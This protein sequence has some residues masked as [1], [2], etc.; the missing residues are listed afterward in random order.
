MMVAPRDLPFR[1]PLRDSICSAERPVLT[2]AALPDC[3][4]QLNRR[5]RPS[6]WFKGKLDD[7][8]ETSL[9]LDNE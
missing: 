8:D 7:V 3:Q 1:K 5:L 9:A 6:S 4:V 2:L